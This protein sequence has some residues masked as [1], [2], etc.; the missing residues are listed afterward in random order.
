MKKKKVIKFRAFTLIEMMTALAIAGVVLAGVGIILADS[1]KS[2]NQMY[3]RLYSDTAEQSH[4]AKAVF[5]S[6]VRKSGKY[7]IEI[8]ENGSTLRLRYFQDSTSEELNRYAYFYLDGYDLK[9]MHGYDGSG[10]SGSDDDNQLYIQKLSSNV[11][12]LKFNAMD[13]SVQMV[14]TLRNADNEMFTIISS[15]VTYN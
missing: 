15:A 13:S 2:W 5:E 11:Y 1:Q 9:V 7:N 3:T 10:I 6:I 14:L 8:D 12:Y 4:H